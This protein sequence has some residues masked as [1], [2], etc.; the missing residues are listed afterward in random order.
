M[1]VETFI[2]CHNKRTSHREAA[3]SFTELAQ[4]SNPWVSHLPR[5]DHR[6][7]A[8][9]DSDNAHRL[10]ILGQLGDQLRVRQR[11]LAARSP[12]RGRLT[13]RVGL[14][15]PDR[16]RQRRADRAL[17][18]LPGQRAACRG[19][20]LCA[21]AAHTAPARTFQGYPP[22]SVGSPHSERPSAALSP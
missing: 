2:T 14:R 9:R 16:I 6:A 5:A 4:L 13:A 1:G 22:A 12:R 8:N 10:I 18:G 15:L 3:A 17:A 7:H 11:D 20:R 19:L 21:I